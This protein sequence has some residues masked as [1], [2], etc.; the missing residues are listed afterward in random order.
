MIYWFLPFLDKLSLLNLISGVEFKDCLLNDTGSTIVYSFQ[1]LLHVF[2][3]RERPKFEIKDDIDSPRNG[4]KPVGEASGTV[5]VTRDTGTE[6]TV[7]VRLVKPLDVPYCY[8]W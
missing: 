4:L 3:C 7:K 6:D 2:S 5:K 1:K 8:L